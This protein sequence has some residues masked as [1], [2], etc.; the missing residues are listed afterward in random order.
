MTQKLA[1][2]LL[3]LV[4]IILLVVACG[5]DDGEATERIPAIVEQVESAVVSVLVQTDGG[6]SQGSGVV[7]D[8]DEGLIVTNCHVVQGARSILVVLADGERLEA[9]V[10]A[11]DRLTDLAVVS[12]NRNDLP[13]IE[14]ATELPV[15]GG[16]AVALGNPLGFENTVTA[17]IVSGL[18]RAIPSGGRTPALIDLIQTDAPISPGNSGGALVDRAGK[19]IGINVAGAPMGNSIGFAVPSP[20]VISVVGQLLGTGDVRH[21]FLGIGRSNLTPDIAQRFAIPPGE[22][23]AVISVVPGS[24]ADGAGLALADVLLELDGSPIR[25]VEDLWAALR[26]RE[27]DDH[28][29]LTLLRAGAAVEVEVTLAE[30]PRELGFDLPLS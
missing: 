16:L 20:T 14:F 15:V 24:P 11:A 22:G 8:S 2:L 26:L 9:T 27:P 6:M 4:A 17:G 30:R 7:W 18:H 10:R 3:F 23:V 1:T 12:V 29:T 5:G 19:V 13:A 25:A 21:A 28:V